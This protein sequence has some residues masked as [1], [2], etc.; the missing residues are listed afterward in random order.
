[1]ALVVEDGSGLPN[2][3]SFISA[4]DA[5]TYH[6]ARGNVAWAA[7]ADDATREIYLRQATDYMEGIY[8]LRWKGYRLNAVQYLSWPRQSVFLTD[9]GATNEGSYYG[10][11]G[12]LVPNNVVPTQVK[13]ACAEFALVAS[14]TPLSPNIERVVKSEKLD[15]IERVFDEGSPVY[16]IFRTAVLKLGPFVSSLGGGTMVGL[17][18]T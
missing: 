18:R 13:Q 8:R 2:A 11:D 12:F 14:S 17:V 7:I 10:G 4:V 16:T 9:I 5:S 3:E 15:V 1:M 6:A